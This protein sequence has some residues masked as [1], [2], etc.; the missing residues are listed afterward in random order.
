M[1]RGIPDKPGGVG[2]DSEDF[3]LEGLKLGFPVWGESGPC[4][5]AICK[6]RSNEGGVDQKLIV[7]G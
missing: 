1:D 4:W 5:A 3:V 7:D 2:D 6:H